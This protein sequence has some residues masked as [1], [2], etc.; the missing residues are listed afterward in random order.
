MDYLNVVVLGGGT[1]LSTLLRGLKGYLRSDAGVA[2]KKFSQYPLQDLTA[3]VTAADD[4]GS[5]GR[6]RDEFDILPPGDI[7][8]CIMGL[9]GEENLLAD[10]FRYR[11]QGDGDLGG[12]SV[13]NILLTALTGMK[14]NFLEAI[15][16]SRELLGIKARVLPCTL[17][18]AHL[19]AELNDGS[20]IFLLGR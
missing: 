3:I 18:K 10:L 13:G 2:E 4:G 19:G 6:I 7:R 11:F 1:G 5:S 15:R 8:N 14:G 12:H 16:C 20:T 17:A 9:A